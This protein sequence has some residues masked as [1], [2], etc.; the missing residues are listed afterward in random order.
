MSDSNRRRGGI[1]AYIHGPRIVFML[2]VLALLLIGFAMVYSAG[3]ITNIDAGASPLKALTDQVVFAAIGLICALIIYFFMPP[4]LWRGRAVYA[5]WAAAVALIL[6]TALFGTDSYGAK[7]WIRIGSFSI[8]PSEFV[9]IALVIVAVRLFSDL[10]EQKVDST[11]FLIGLA[12]GIAVPL[13]VMYKTQS[14][15]GTSMICLVA[16]LAVFWYG[17]MPL[18]P[19]VAIVAAVFLLGVIAIVGVGYRSDRFSYLN[20]WDDGQ[21][22]YGTGYNIIHSYYAFSEGGLFGVGLGNGHEKYQYLFASDSDFIFAV[23]GEELGLVGALSVIALF[24]LLAYMGMKIANAASDQF[25]TMLA[26]A[27]TVALVFQAFLNMGCAAGVFPT[28]GK[29]LP[30]ISSGGSSVIA[31][32]MMVGI[33]LSV[34]RDAASSRVYD[35]RR[36][37]LRVVR[38]SDSGAR[39]TRDGRRPEGAPR[40]PRPSRD[41]HRSGRDSGSAEYAPSR[42]QTTS[43]AQRSRASA[44]RR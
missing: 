10:R 36:A 38:T 39:T 21:G 15:L 29:P 24:L 33:I 13:L 27:L 3:S 30:F 40:A 25:G 6:A 17:E 22:G 26:G 8:Q 37:D 41:A 18:G 20:P 35:R 2:T 43:Q 11:H 5:V 7:R 16:L 44:R 28:T 12:L 34:S 19:F 9:K 4:S 23:I 32:L 14:D 42:A 1:P 31:S